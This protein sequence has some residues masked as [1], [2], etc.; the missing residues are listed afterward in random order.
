MADALYVGSLVVENLKPLPRGE[1]NIEMILSSNSAGQITADAM[2]LDSSVN[3]APQH[4]SVSLADVVED[5]G[6][7]DGI[8]DFD[9]DLDIEPH[10]HPP[11]GLY[12]TVPAPGFL[13]HKKKFPWPLLITAGVLL[14][15]FGGLLY[16]FLTSRGIG[17]RDALL[18][19]VPVAVPAAPAPPRE[20]TPPPVAPQAQATPVPE[21]QVVAPPAPRT[22]PMAP[23][24]VISAAQQ[25]PVVASGE[26]PPDRTR[27]SAPA[28]SST[29]PR[30][31][32]QGGMPYTIRWG[33]TLWD[34]SE[35]FYRN[36]WLYLSIARFNAIR[37]PD[38]I[39][40]GNTIRIPPRN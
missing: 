10:E 37:N 1:P 18:R 26:T 27:T 4:L 32:P 36:P 19:S 5:D 17:L 31:I 39:I 22:A 25:P 33:D 7:N 14:L 38:F 35:A 3:G 13:E 2:D 21:Q 40:A 11:Q 34:I 20:Q 8:P 28:A 30:T 15:A 6:A 16:F 9:L 24:P 23:P 29:V 12:G